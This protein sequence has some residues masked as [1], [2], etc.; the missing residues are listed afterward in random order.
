MVCWIAQQLSLTQGGMS[1]EI[2][3]QEWINKTL[4]IRE[5][6]QW[7]SGMHQNKLRLFLNE[8][9]WVKKSQFAELVFYISA[10]KRTVVHTKQLGLKFVDWTGSKVI[11]L[12]KRKLVNIFKHGRGI[13]IWDGGRGS[14]PFSGMTRPEREIRAAKQKGQIDCRASCK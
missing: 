7:F 10:T 4:R 2:S 12:A 8:N 11:Y 5:V 6:F 13:W 1:V 3:Y 14:P 9:V